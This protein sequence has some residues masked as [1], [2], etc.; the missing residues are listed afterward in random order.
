MNEITPFVYNI[1]TIRQS[2]NYLFYIFLA[3]CWCTEITIEYLP[4]LRGVT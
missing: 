4:S 2:S 1:L 3:L